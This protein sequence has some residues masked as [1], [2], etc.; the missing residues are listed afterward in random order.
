[1]AL[2]NRAG[3]AAAAMY[4]L[5]DLKF[6]GTVGIL[7]S[8]NAKSPGSKLAASTREACAGLAFSPDGRSLAYAQTWHDVTIVDLTNPQTPLS[9]CGSPKEYTHLR[10]VEIF[11]NDTGSHIAVTGG[12]TQYTP[13]ETPMI[14]DIKTKRR[15]TWEHKKDPNQANGVAFFAGGQR[16]AASANHNGPVYVVDSENQAI[17]GTIPVNLTSIRT[18]SWDPDLLVGLSA[19]S[20]NI[21]TYS[22]SER[23]CVQN[24]TKQGTIGNLCLS[25]DHRQLA[26]RWEKR[27]KKEKTDQPRIEIASLPTGKLLSVIDPAPEGKFAWDAEAGRIYCYDGMNIIVFAS[28]ES[29]GTKP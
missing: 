25:P 14:W 8:Y 9:K 17:V 2:T 20:D 15:I 6:L 12:T 24:L 13:G 21:S 22:I 7:A 28:P 5:P 23:R 1:V 18:L 26:W 4:E 10:P 27:D 19:S 3:D 29:A 16:F 11:F